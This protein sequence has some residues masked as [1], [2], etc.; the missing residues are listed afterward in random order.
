MALGECTECMQ[1]MQHPKLQL[2]TG[3]MQQQHC[4]CGPPLPNFRETEKNKCK[5]CNAPRLTDLWNLQQKQLHQ[6]QPQSQQRH[7]H[8]HQHQRQWK[9]KAN[10][11]ERF[12]YFWWEEVKGI[13]PKIPFGTDEISR[14]SCNFRAIKNNRRLLMDWTRSRTRVTVIRGM[15]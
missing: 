12:S 11:V 15:P 9:T 14:W 6:Q 13:Y 4:L 5:M 2:A 10:G 8:Q 7:Q 1:Q 3:K